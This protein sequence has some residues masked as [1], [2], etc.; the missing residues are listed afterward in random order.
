MMRLRL[1]LSSSRLGRVSLS[2][3]NSILPK[4]LGP[5]NLSAFIFSIMA[6]AFI[7]AAGSSIFMGITGA[8]GA[9]TATGDAA[10]FSITVGIV[11]I[12]NGTATFSSTF[13]VDFLGLVEESIAS[14]SIFVTTLGASSSGASILVSTTGGA[15]SGVGFTESGIAGSGA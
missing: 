2:T 11:S 9:I 12:F 10:G 1:R 8:A 14:K 4:I 5:S 6:G 3:G 15:S 13:L 7:I